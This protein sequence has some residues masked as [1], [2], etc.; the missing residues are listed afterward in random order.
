MLKIIPPGS[1]GWDQTVAA[2]IKTSSRGLRGKDFGDFIKRA[3]HDFLSALDQLRPGEVPLHLIGIGATEWYGPNRNGDG[4]KEATCRARHHTFVKHA[5]FFRD[6]DNGRN[7]HRYGRIIASGYHEP[8]HRV[9]LLVGLYRT[10]EAARLGGGELGR[11]ADKEIH[12]IESGRD[13]PVSM[14]CRVPHDIC[15]HCFNKAASRRE[16]CDTR[17]VILPSRIV[18]ACSGFGAA[19]GL[20]K[21]AADGS[22]QHVDNPASLTFTDMSKVY[23]NADRVAFGF[24]LQ[25][26]ASDLIVP[27][28]A[29]LAEM[30]GLEDHN[31][32]RFMRQGGT[33][34]VARQLDALRDLADAADRIDVRLGYLWK[35]GADAM[36]SFPD[37]S[38]SPRVLA[39]ALKAAADEHIVLGVAD[40]MTLVM[41]KQ[42]AAEAAADVAAQLPGVYHRMLADEEGTKQALADN[43][44]TPDDG[45]P[46]LK[47]R[48]WAAKHAASHGA[49][50]P[51]LDRR[52][53]LGTIRDGRDIDEISPAEF[54]SRTKYASDGGGAEMLAREYAKY[55]AA[56]LASQPDPDS[57]AF[58]LTTT[59][60]ATESRL[61]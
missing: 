38:A 44:Y 32:E 52:A 42:A 34:K 14:A 46:P 35:R 19:R 33:S 11:V 25:K 30:L 4:F 3:G 54:S 21:V 1:Y 45:V 18:A 41:G 15:S 17:E 12:D 20:T 31:A 61:G 10:K 43:P 60:L 27:G 40:W 9:E 2:L 26:A 37:V 55:Q 57:A 8:M 24:G 5:H 48:L 58:H 7:S 23:R 6:H 50:R 29:A 59:L 36:A 22:I 16:Y 28:G 53:V 13:L 39:Q 49:L 56:M 47:L 51:H